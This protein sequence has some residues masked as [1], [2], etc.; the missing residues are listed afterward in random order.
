MGLLTGLLLQPGGIERL[1]WVYDHF[2]PLL[3]AS[4]AMSLA[5]AGW[6][7]A[8]SFFSGELLALGGNSGRFFYDFWMGRPLNPTFP[9]F[10]SFDIKTFNE[11][12]PGIIGWVVLNV[13]CACEQYLRQG[14]VSDSMWLVIAFEGYYAADCLYSEVR[15]PLLLVFSS[16]ICYVVLIVTGLHP[17]PDGHHHRWLWL[18]AV[19]RR[20]HVAAV[21]LRSA[22]A[23]S[24]FPPC[25]PGIS[26]VRRHPRSRT[27]RVVC[28][29]YGQQRKVR[30]PHGPQPKE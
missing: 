12:R 22:S 4:V 6:V 21:H 15:L 7:Y 2:V 11:V 14:R 16:G 13:A 20:S 26:L 10:P 5:Q 1:S 24:R 27:D 29:P 8:Y 30:F 18:Y 3:S 19:F 28:L 9:G 17:R 25:S 23:L